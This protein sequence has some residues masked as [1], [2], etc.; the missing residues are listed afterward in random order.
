MRATIPSDA[1]CEGRTSSTRQAHDGR[2]DHHWQQARELLTDSQNYMK[3]VVGSNLRAEVRMKSGHSFWAKYQ[4]VGKVINLD[5][6]SSDYWSS[7][8]R[9][10]TIL[11]QSL[12][13]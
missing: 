13:P 11:S 5:G 9:E 8:N 10:F 3:V 6:L 7:S 4:E 12:W 2:T 1:N